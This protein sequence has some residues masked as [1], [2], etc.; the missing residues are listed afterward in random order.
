MPCTRAQAVPA[1]TGMGHRHRLAGQ[2]ARPV[3]D[4]VAPQVIG[5]R[6]GFDALAGERHPQRVRDLDDVHGDLAG[7]RVLAD[8]L[9]EHLVDLRAVGLELGQV[10]EAHRRHETRFAVGMH[11]GVT[12]LLR[13]T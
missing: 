4:A 8:G 10:R 13:C 2:P 6:F 7:R 11:A 1:S 5:L 3:P 12:L 9:D